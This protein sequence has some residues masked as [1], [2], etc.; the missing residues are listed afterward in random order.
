VIGGVARGPDPH[1]AL[2]AWPVAYNLT[3]VFIVLAQMLQQV[4]IARARHAEA[5]AAV[6][7]FVATAS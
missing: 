4:V 6:R 7:R 3:L 1:L 5:R 2:A